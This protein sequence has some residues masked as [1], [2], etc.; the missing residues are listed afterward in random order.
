MLRIFVANPPSDDAAVE[1]ARYASDGRVV[2]RGREVPRRLPADAA[3]EVVLAA[4]YVRLVTLDLPPMPRAR[5][6]QAVRYALEDQMATSAEEAAIAFTDVDRRVLVAITSKALVDAIVERIPRVSRIV[7][8]SALAPFGEGWTWFTSAGEGGFVRRED[9]S[10]FAV[11]SSQASLPPE[12]EAAL[13]AAQRAGAVPS[14]VRAPVQADSPQ[15]TDWSRTTGTRFVAAPAWNWEAATSREFATAPDFHAGDSTREP[16]EAPRANAFRLAAILAALALAIHVGALLTQWGFLAF[17]DWQLS[18]AIV[19]EAADAG[20]ANVAGAEA[21]A[22]A[23]S[24]Q[25]A[26]LAHRAG[27]YAPQDAL[28]LLARAAPSLAALPR[29]SVRSMAYASDA[30]TIEV[31]GVDT[32]IVSHLARSLDDAG[33]RSVAAPVSGGTRMRLTLDAAYR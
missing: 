15:L 9:G 17:T 2:S 18:R 5:L 30:W 21:A 11:A 12:L 23:I 25:H 28:P 22:A 29:T 33:V 24:R 1:W 7:A 10:A 4:S 3:I 19:R 14:V 13:I 31:A 6:R 26:A 27:Q 8:E 16:S 32:S 20:I